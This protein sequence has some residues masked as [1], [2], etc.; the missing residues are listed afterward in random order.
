MHDQVRRQCRIA[1]G[2]PEPTATVIDPQ[3]V[4]AAEEVARPVAAS[5]PGRRRSTAAP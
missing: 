3:A 1:A 5:A 2:R 4:K